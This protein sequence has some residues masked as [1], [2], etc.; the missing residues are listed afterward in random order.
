M[1]PHFYTK[2]R[3]QIDKQ[4]QSGETKMIGLFNTKAALANK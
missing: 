4:K 1:S 3:G 2:P